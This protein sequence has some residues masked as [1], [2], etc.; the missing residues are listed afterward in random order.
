MPYS[1][2]PAFEDTGRSPVR[3][4]EGRSPGFGKGRGGGRPPVGPHPHPRDR[5]SASI[6]FLGFL[7]L[8]LLVALGAV[9]LGL[10]A[11]AAQQ[12]GTAARAAARTATVDGPRGGGSPAAAARAAVTGWV[13]DRAAVDATPCQAAAGAVTATVTV[14]VPALLPGTGFSVTRTATMA[15]PAQGAGP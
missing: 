14:D 2:C 11:F 4:A 13:A 9:H 8:L 5:G 6:E 3:G 10:A 15:C 12:A 1:A 7:P